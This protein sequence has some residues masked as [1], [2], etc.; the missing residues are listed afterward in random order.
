MLYRHHN[1]RHDGEVWLVFSTPNGVML[2][3]Q[4]GR[5]PD[6]S[7]LLGEGRSQVMND[8]FADEIVP[9]QDRSDEEL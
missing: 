4:S 9:F 7:V 8:E 3:E 6:N 1:R 2:M 5:W